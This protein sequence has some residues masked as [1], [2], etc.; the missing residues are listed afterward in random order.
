MKGM[1]EGG[2]EGGGK[3]RQTAEGGEGGREGGRQGYREG[4]REGGRE[5]IN[6]QLIHSSVM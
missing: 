1:D 5:S 2:W 3:E 6:N 4:W